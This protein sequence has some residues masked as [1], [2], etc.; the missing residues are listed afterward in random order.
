M[1][2]TVPIGRHGSVARLDLEIANVVDVGAKL[3]LRLRIDLEDVAELGDLA[4]IVGTDIVGEGG[5]QLSNGDAKRLRLDAVYIDKDL[6]RARAECRGD[7]LKR[8]L[9]VGVGDH[10][11]GQS[12]KQGVVEIPIPK[13]DLHR[14]AADV[15]DALDWRRGEREGESLRHALQPAVEALE[16]RADVLPWLFETRVPILQ[17]DEGDAGVG[18]ARQIVENGYA[19]DGDHVLDPGN[20][21]GHALD[22][23]QH[24]I[25]P[26]L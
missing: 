12:L 5:E 17:D 22:L 24:P 1:S 2:T 20:L 7:P 13:F 11:V 6:R 18:E 3:G 9:R 25:C 15:A 19:A 4:D 21:A 23:L 10:G 8:R 26:L 14:E 16:D